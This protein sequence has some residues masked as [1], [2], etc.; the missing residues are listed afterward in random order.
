M[1]LLKVNLSKQCKIGLDKGEYLEAKGEVE[2][3]EVGTSA[4]EVKWEGVSKKG[5]G[6]CRGA[7]VDG[8]VIR[9]VVEMR[10]ELE[11]EISGREIW[12]EVNVT[13][14]VGGERG[15]RELGDGEVGGRVGEIK[16][17]EEEEEIGIEDRAW[18]VTVEVVVVELVED[19]TGRV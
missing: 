7:L 17:D 6:I 10:S 5:L 14:S 13:E 19:M 15:E 2:K 18:V 9:E 1:E 11:R 8:V 12:G 16:E 4:V 3:R